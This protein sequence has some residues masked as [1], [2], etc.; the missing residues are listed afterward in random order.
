MRKSIHRLLKYTNFLITII[1]IVVGGFSVDVA[2]GRL[3]EN[4][5]SGVPLP[6]E[7]LVQFSGDINKTEAISALNRNSIRFRSMIFDRY[8]NRALVSYDPESA[9]VIEGITDGK[10]KISGI[11]YV[12][13]AYGD[14]KCREFLI[15]EIAVVL[16]SPAGI[17][18][19][20]SWCSLN[21]C[22][23]IRI[24]QWYDYTGVLIRVDNFSEERLST[25]CSELAGFEESYLVQPNVLKF[26]DPAS[27]NPDD[28]YF[29]DQWALKNTGMNGWLEDADIDAPEGW[30]L[31]RGSSE[32]IIA[33]LDMG[34]DVEHEEF[35][36]KIVAPY[37]AVDGTDEQTPNDW[38]AHGTCCAGIAAARTD[39]NKGIAG[40]NWNAQI[41]P[42]KIGYTP[43]PG[44]QRMVT[45]YWASDG[46]LTA[47]QR[48]ADVLS[49]SWY[50]TPSDLIDLAFYTVYQTGRDG[51]GCIS[52]AAAGNFNSDLVYPASLPETF[53]VGATS[54]CDERKS[55]TSCDGETWW[56]SNYGQGLD[57][58]AP[59][60]YIWT[61]DI[62]G[63]G[64]SN[65]GNPAY[66]DPL[67]DYVSRFRGTS[68]AT[69]QV[70]GLAAIIL[71]IDPEM[72]AFEVQQ[73]I[74]DNTDDLG[75]QGWDEEFGYGRIN[76]FKTI[77][78]MDRVIRV[79]GN[80][81]EDQVWKHG[82][83]YLVENSVNIESDV[84]I[85]IEGG[86]V[87]KFNPEES[88]EV[89]GILRLEGTAGYPVVFTSYRDDEYGGDTNGDGPSNGQMCD[90][91]KITINNPA[92]E[93]HDVIMRYAGHDWVPLPYDRSLETVA[94]YDGIQD[95]TFQYCG[96]NSRGVIDINESEDFQFIISDLTFENCDYWAINYNASPTIPP[97]L[98]N[99]DV[100][101]AQGIYMRYEQNGSPVI[102]YCVVSDFNS[103]DGIYYYGGYSY[104]SHPQIFN[105]RVDGGSYSTGITVWSGGDQSSIR[106]NEII[107]NQDGIRLENY[108]GEVY[109]NNI[110]GN[111]GY[112]LINNSGIITI[113]AD[114]NW[115]G[116]PDG[117]SGGGSGSGDA[118]SGN[119][120]YQPYLTEP[121]SFYGP[122]DIVVNHDAFHVDMHP[123]EII[124]K[125]FRITNRGQSELVYDVYEIDSI[126]GMNMNDID[127]QTLNNPLSDDYKRIAGYIVDHDNRDDVSWLEPVPVSGALDTGQTKD[128]MVNF[129]SGEMVPDRYSCL[130]SVVSNDP[131]R[132]VYNLPVYLNVEQPVE[133][134]VIMLP[135]D[136]PAHVPHTGGEFGYTGTLRNNTGQY[137]TLDLWLTVQ[138]PVGE[139]LGPFYKVDNIRM[140]PYETMVA[141][142]LSKYVPGD[143]MAGDY[144]FSA[145]GGDYPDKTDSCSF[146]VT[147]DNFRG[148][149]DD[150]NEKI[151]YS[152]EAVFIGEPWFRNSGDE[153]LPLVLS[154]GN[155]YPNPFNAA[156]S[157]S[158]ELPYP[159]DVRLEVYNLMGQRVTRLAGGYHKAGRY[160]VN[161]DASDYS[162]GVYFY[163]L[164]A[165]DATIVK[166]MTLLK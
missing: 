133:F 11:K 71:S 81:R 61:T 138:T 50:T 123:A 39:N 165:G 2:S 118:I 51:R 38:D 13:P 158:Y 91:G 84:T 15:D 157:I 114:S 1:T 16:E 152:G 159:A 97:H 19:I 122:P 155:N 124:A 36:D 164:T 142:N 46:I 115:W 69:P 12:S 100:S 44:G 41:M 78:A 89:N 59:G 29:D 144:I 85:T 4:F 58:M 34:V 136:P 76:I 49:N 96:G 166:R 73:L 150:G 47:A 105:N 143:M 107:N 35:I 9:S 162:S 153:N 48:G 65:P 125:Q 111:S 163:R 140:A 109:S 5:Y 68:S 70:A 132:P 104:V 74:I 62:T 60:C 154:L 21:G 25:A 149:K 17:D 99:V 117:P 130:L 126:P 87:V 31:A 37:N 127:I 102:A 45:D 90:W 43:E 72:T 82:N 121:A 119:I 156:T 20:E 3:A 139:V 66:G 10:A 160:S 116:A 63:G 145:I 106:F 141:A 95:C 120:A 52:V 161:W 6:G 86:T 22:S 101:G 64:G 32:I 28:T 94:L 57:V 8:A 80:I 18:R 33:V 131:A 27:V 137:Q 26:S 148:N 30:E 151:S 14:E 146:I 134:S 77:S 55:P 92:S 88:M 24:R 7:C 54:P 79:D 147:K 103:G 23:V 83:V 113:D 98:V 93:F 108:S 56:G 110:E 67:G 75:P 40:V 129:Y 53:A 128:I 135:D 112:G 42:I